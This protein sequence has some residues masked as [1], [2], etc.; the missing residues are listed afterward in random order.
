MEMLR[1]RRLV[2]DTALHTKGWSRQ[3]ALAYLMESPGETETEAT[4]EID[5]YIAWPGQALSYKI[6]E[7]KIK[8]MR[9]KAQREL[10]NRFDIREF[11]DQLINSGALPLRVLEA[12][13]DR[14][15][16]REKSR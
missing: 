7:L 16:I 2:L 10:G 8:G 4:L 5:R 9:A 13:M 6:G 14:W 12:K 11:H 3:K 15:I 1:A